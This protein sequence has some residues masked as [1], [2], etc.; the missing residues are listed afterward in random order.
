MN[1]VSIDVSKG[2][3]TVT[4]R[5][6]ADEVVMPP[7]DFPHIQSGINGLIEQIRSL[8]VESKV[9]MEIPADTMNRSPP[10]S[11][12]P[13]SLSAQSTPSSSGILAMTPCGHPK[14]TRRMRKDRP[15]YS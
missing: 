3:S 6:P 7:C 11:P 14:L 15:L 8:D 1:A 9:C 13:E 5:R 10:G 4:I 2:K 12:M